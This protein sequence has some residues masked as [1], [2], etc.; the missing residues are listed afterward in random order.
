M[1][2]RG[3]WFHSELGKPVYS[4]WNIDHRD[5]SKALVVLNE[6]TI[7]RSLRELVTAVYELTNNIS[8]QRHYMV[9]Y[10]LDKIT[11]ALIEIAANEP[12]LWRTL[13]CSHL[14]WNP[15]RH[16]QFNRKFKQ[17]AFQLLLVAQR[18]GMPHWFALQSIAELAKL[19]ATR[20]YYSRPILELPK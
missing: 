10:R 11:L 2:T 18:T 1:Y 3:N 19:E 20:V 6:K 13:D 7:A 9:Q 17:R 4:N 15:I 8:T 5:A 12:K 16:W 14:N